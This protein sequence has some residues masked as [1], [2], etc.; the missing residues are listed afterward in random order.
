KKLP[1]F[2]VV[3]VRRHYRRLQQLF[4]AFLTDRR[5]IFKYFYTSSRLYCVRNIHSV[6]SSAAFVKRSSIHLITVLKI[7]FFLVNSLNISCSSFG[8]IMSAL[9]LE[10]ISSWNCSESFGDTSPSFSP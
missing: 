10:E 1:G 8:Y 2:S 5:T 3:M 7:S 6:F 4:H 9:S